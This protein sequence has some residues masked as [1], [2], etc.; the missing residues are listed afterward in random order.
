MSEDSGFRIKGWHVLAGFVGAFGIIISVNIFMAYNAVTTFPGLEVSNGY[1]AS[2]SFD[3]RRAEQEKLGW[4]VL[5]EVE[6][7]RLI[8]AITDADGR[9]VQAGAVEATVGRPTENKHDQNPEL[10]FDGRSYTAPM[11]LGAGKWILR[12]KAQSLDGVPFE[13]RLDVHVKS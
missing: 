3:K 10:V 1:I 6:E 5:A 12:F 8:V 7:G 11:D 13:Q 4:T 9:A 2:Q